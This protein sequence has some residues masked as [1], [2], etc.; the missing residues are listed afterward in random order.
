MNEEMEALQKNAIWELVPQPKGMK[1]IGCG[2]VFMVK[3]KPNGN[4]NRYKARLVTKGYTQR[5]GVDYQDTFTPVAKI[6]TIRILIS[7]AA[8]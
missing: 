5:Y 3:L 7:I 8:N 6:N 2:W 4:I 1:T